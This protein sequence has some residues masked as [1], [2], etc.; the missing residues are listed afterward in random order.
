VAVSR[1]PRFLLIPLVATAGALVPTVAGAD[2]PPGA[3][4]AVF[5]GEPDVRLV[6]MTDPPARSEAY[7]GQT[8]TA[9]I[10]W[11]AGDWDAL[12]SMLVC[13]RI[14]DTFHPEMSASEDVPTNDGG[15]GHSFV[16]PEGLPRGTFICTQA[17]L[18]GDPAGEAT[19]ASMVSKK[20]C[21][22]VHPDAQAGPPANNPSPSP[23]PPPAAA[24]AP[25]PPAPAPAPAP[26]PS[27]P[28][29]EGAGSV[30]PP[31][32]VPVAAPATVSESPPPI[33]ER[34]A[35][36][37]LRPGGPIYLDE[38]PR[39]GAPLGWLAVAGFGALSFGVPALAVGRRRFRR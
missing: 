21:L 27:S 29:S 28:P 5:S 26:Q 3:C 8:V 34:P 23:T 10:G 24:P 33:V 11:A 4:D 15:G 35:G 31:D 9:T 32:H 39:T 18:S 25:P 22:E 36:A 2:I 14:V 6:L 16:V 13:V 37:P 17:H 1:I 20:S 19:E 38:L 7:P 12:K 30:N